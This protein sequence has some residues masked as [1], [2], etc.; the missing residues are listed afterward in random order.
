MGLK[1]VVSCL[2]CV[3]A[4][5][6]KF[7]CGDCGGHR[8]CGCVPAWTKRAC[9]LINRVGLQNKIRGLQ[10]WGVD[11]ID[12]QLD[13]V[14]AVCV[15][16]QRAGCGIIAQ[17]ARR[18]ES[19]AADESEGVVGSATDGVDGREVDHVLA[20]GEDE[21]I[22][23]CAAINHAVGG[24]ID[25]A[26]IACAAVAVQF[27]VACEAVEIVVASSA[28]DADERFIRAVDDDCDLGWLPSR[29]LTV[30]VSVRDWPK[31]RLCTAVRLL[32][33]A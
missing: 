18:S 21:V 24:V 23:P 20:C 9:G 3:Q 27:V 25:P 11:Q 14:V 1:S 17:L 33:S 32:F 8:G 31:L 30:L 16:L 6:R 7:C 22:S 2:S 19:R 10:H 28:D 5:T 12:V 15:G 13:N 26:V 4:N 29:L